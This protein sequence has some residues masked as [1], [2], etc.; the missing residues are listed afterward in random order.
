MIAYRGDPRFAQGFTDTFGRGPGGTV[1]DPGLIPAL[2]KQGEEGGQLILRALYVKEQ[3]GPVKARHTAD[4]RVQVQQPDD[5]A[6]YI[7]GGRCGKGRDHGP[8]RQGGH[9]VRDLQVAGAEILSPLGDA[10]G[11]IHRRQGDIH[12][13]GKRR[14]ALCVQPFRR[15]VQQLV[16]PLPRPAVY[17]PQL[18][19]GQRAVDIRGGYAGAL[20]RG[21]LVL[22]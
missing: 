14:K 19:Q 5:V 22:H 18:L 10:V 7:H 6:L 1:H 8:V 11:L 13:P 20:Q 15:D 12:F 9:E 16:S 21:H 17:L 4:R 3:V 2:A